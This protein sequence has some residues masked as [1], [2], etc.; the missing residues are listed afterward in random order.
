MNV[1]NTGD[2]PFAKENS[3]HSNIA[4][5]LLLGKWFR[6]L[7]EQEVYDNTRIIIASDHGRNINS[8]YT[9]NMRLPSNEWLSFYHAL[10]L[11][12]DFNERGNL[13]TDTTFMTHGDVPVIAMEGIIDNP[14]NPFSGK[15][16]KSDK[17]NGIF[18]TTT[19][20]L[21]FTIKNDQ[22]L[23]VHDNIFDPANWKKVKK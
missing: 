1:T 12:K 16:I 11:V 13:V 4:A 5:I 20:S 19:S 2:G 14:Q 18:I 22:W 6:F 7:Q 10:L 21:E 8:N 15:H 9:G 23:H 3:Y 17:E